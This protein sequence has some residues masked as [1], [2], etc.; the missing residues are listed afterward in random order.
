MITQKQFEIIDHT[1]NRAARNLF[2]GGGEDMTVLVKAGFMRPAGVKSFVPDPYYTVTDKGRELH[3][4]VMISR[5]QKGKT[6]LV[7]AIIQWHAEQQPFFINIRPDMV[8]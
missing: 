1:I 6:N 8:V 4:R 2:C 3:R 5:R 7:N